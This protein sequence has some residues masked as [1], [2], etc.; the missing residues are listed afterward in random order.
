MDQRMGWAYILAAW[1]ASKLDTSMA[2]VKMTGA[3]ESESGSEKGRWSF[4]LPVGRMAISH[5]HER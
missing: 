5:H 3:S 2:M 1:D 4:W